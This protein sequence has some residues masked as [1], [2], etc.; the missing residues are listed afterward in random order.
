MTSLDQA[1]SYQGHERQTVHAPVVFTTPGEAREQLLGLARCA[2]RQLAIWTT[3]M[4]VGQLEDPAFIDAIKRFVLARRQ[5]RVRVL[6]P[7]LPQLSNCNDHKHALLAMAERLPASIEIRTANHPGLDASELLL[8]DERG[9]YYRI[10]IDRWDGMADQQ[11]PMV[12]RFYLAQF[13]MAWRAG[14]TA[15]T[16]EPLDSF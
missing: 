9:V 1:V 13:N 11:D 7:A 8:S 4:T 6:T 5:A 2:E 3:D 15:L 12:A 14:A 10:H 16:R